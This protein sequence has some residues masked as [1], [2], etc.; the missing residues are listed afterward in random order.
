[1]THF[2]R[3]GFGEFQ[4]GH[5]LGPVCWPHFDLFFVHEGGVTL[6]ETAA[7]AKSHRL[8][9]GQGVLIG[10]VTQF[11]GK[12]DGAEGAR[13]S[14]QH[15]AYRDR[16]RGLLSDVLSGVSGITPQR[17]APSAQLT[18]DVARAVTLARR[19][20]GS[21]NLHRL[22][23]ALLLVVL[24]TGGFLESDGN[25]SGSMP[26]RIDLGLAEQVVRDHLEFGGGISALA[27][28]FGLSI[29]RFRAVFQAEHG[30]T[31]GGFVRQIRQQEMER[32]LTET[33]LPLKEIARRVGVADAVVLGRVFRRATGITPAIYRR[34]NR[35]LG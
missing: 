11:G 22:R 9:A 35:I 13:A 25:S 19:D 17:V 3:H 16:P 28:A 33:H 21:A 14:I 34:Q 23:E 8:G 26:P 1:M 10:P 4:P 18:A 20:D 15:F 2:R 6:A 32:W 12:V 5:K 27:D 29:S 31:V 24:E 7:G 30:Q